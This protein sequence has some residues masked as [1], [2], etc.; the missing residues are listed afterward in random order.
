MGFVIGIYPGG[1]NITTPT[2]LK[3]SF[4][5]LGVEEKVSFEAQ[6]ILAASLWAWWYRGPQTRTGKWSLGVDGGPQLTATKVTGP[7][8]YN[9]LDFANNELGYGFLPETSR[10]GLSPPS[11]LISALWY[12]EQLPRLLIFGTELI[13]VLFYTCDNL[14]Y[15]KRIPIHR[16]CMYSF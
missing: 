5:Q 14:L 12:R 11:T 9:L 8:S 2:T 4:L 10:W 6:G 13:M 15:S 3:A 1:P 16:V 7:Q